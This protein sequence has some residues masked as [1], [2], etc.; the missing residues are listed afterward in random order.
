MD[1]LGDNVSDTLTSTVQSLLQTNLNPELYFLPPDTEV[2]LYFRKVDEFDDD[3]W[4]NLDW[5]KYGGIFMG[6]AMVVW[7]GY[8]VYASIYK[9]ESKVTLQRSMSDLLRRRKVDAAETKDL[10]MFDGFRVLCLIWIL[11]F[12][13]A[14]FTMGGAAYNPWTLQ[15]YFQTVEYTL[16]YSANFGFDEFFMLST[17]FAYIKLSKYISENGGF[18]VKDYFKV[19]VSRFLRLVPVY[20]VIFLCGW[21]IGPY[22][23]SGP[24]WYTYQMGFCDCQNYW[25]SVFTMTINEWPGYVVANEG[26]FYWGWFTA[27]EM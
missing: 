15:D 14:Q 10:I 2:E 24:W 20:Y 7:C 5:Q 13:V 26:C 1:S 17:F 18:T 4:L 3:Y 19:Y 25:W 9:A 8:I 21:L 22:L 27:C 23:A 11:T 12:G 16:V 6:I